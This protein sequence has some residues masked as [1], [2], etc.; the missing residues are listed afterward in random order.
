MTT[1]VPDPASF[2]VR[3]VARLVGPDAPVPVMDV[4]RQEERGDGWT[5]GRWVRSAWFFYGR[6]GYLSIFI[7]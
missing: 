3:D 6:V 2:A 5:L 7:H 4:E 1:T